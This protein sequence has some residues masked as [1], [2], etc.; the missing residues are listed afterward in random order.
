MDSLDHVLRDEPRLAEKRIRIQAK[1]PALGFSDLHL[2]PNPSCPM[3]DRYTLP[4]MGAVWTQTRKYE[5]WLKIE[6]AVCE[7]MEHTGKVPRGVASRIQKKVTVNPSRIAAIEQVTKHDVI[8]FLESVAEQAGK[9]GRFL[10][11]GLT[12][13]DIVDT[14]LA[15]QMVEATKLIL[16]DVKELLEVHCGIWLSRTGIP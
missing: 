10:H 13:S 4:R 1:I 15:L 6:L 2:P 8:A 5:L 11:V 7:A 3:I 14:S 16:D 12:S 9:D